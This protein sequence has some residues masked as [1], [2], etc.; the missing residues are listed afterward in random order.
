[1]GS[2]DEVGNNT[3]SALGHTINPVTPRQAARKTGP[4]PGAYPLDGA[5]VQPHPEPVAH[6][7]GDLGPP[8]RCRRR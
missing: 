6:L 5:A 7:L 4:S 8:T 1:M 2:G 3:G